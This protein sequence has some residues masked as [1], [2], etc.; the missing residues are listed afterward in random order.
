MDCFLSYWLNM[1]STPHIQTLNS[2][3]PEEQA[4]DCGFIELGLIWGSLPFLVRC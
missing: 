3:M 1:S 4:Q 2:G